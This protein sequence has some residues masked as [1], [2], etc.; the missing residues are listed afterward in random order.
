MLERFAGTAQRSRGSIA[1][2]L[3]KI[4]GD[5]ADENDPTAIAERQAA[6]R[7]DAVGDFF[8]DASRSHD[9][10]SGTWVLLALRR[11]SRGRLS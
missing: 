5:H 2:F 4:G 6:A 7:R 3:I 10:P 11:P 9:A 1:K 8:A